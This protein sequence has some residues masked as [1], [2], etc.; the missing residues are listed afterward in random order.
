MSS[1]LWRSSAIAGLAFAILPSVAHSQ[2]DRGANRPPEPARFRFM[3]P[4]VGGRISAVAGIPGDSLTIYFGA[5]S[6]GIWKSTDG[7]QT[8]APVFDSQPTAASSPTN[9]GRL[10]KRRG[11]V[12]FQYVDHTCKPAPEIQGDNKLWTGCQL[13]VVGPERDTTTQRWFG[14]IV[15]RGGTFKF[16]TLANQ[17]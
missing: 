16:L 6:G 12:Q 7:G 2:R 3:G 1:G 15:E 10:L 5:A 8:N 14:V 13:R 9:S 4:A 17:F 11:G